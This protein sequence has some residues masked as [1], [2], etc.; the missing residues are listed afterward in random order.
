MLLN[1][2]CNHQIHKVEYPHLSEAYS[3]SLNFIHS[4]ELFPGLKDHFKRFS[5]RDTYIRFI[6]ISFKLVFVSLTILSLFHFISLFLWLSL[7]LYP[8]F[9]SRISLN[10]YLLNKPFPTPHNGS[11]EPLLCLIALNSYT[12]PK[13]GWEEAY[14]VGHYHLQSGRWSGVRCQVAQQAPSPLAPHFLPP[15]LVIRI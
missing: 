10:V 12:F 3:T 6:W 11:F 2:S 7:S 13:V 5:F 1:H 15:N 9:L 8:F 4:Q 14:W